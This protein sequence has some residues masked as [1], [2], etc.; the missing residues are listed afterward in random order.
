MHNPLKNISFASDLFST[1]TSCLFE[2]IFARIILNTCMHPLSS[3]SPDFFPHRPVILGCGF[4]G[5]WLQYK[6]YNQDI[7]G[8]LL[9]SYEQLTVGAAD[10]TLPA[11]CSDLKIIYLWSCSRSNLSGSSFKPLK[12]QSP[13]DIK[14]GLKRSDATSLSVKWVWEALASARIFS[15]LYMWFCS[16]CLFFSWPHQVSSQRK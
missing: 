3:M 10:D 2:M 1:G 14:P 11:V 9:V 6:Q 5:R 15:M 7:F 12:L 13:I 4:S 16:V 8:I